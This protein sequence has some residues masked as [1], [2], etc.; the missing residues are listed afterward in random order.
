[1][2]KIVQPPLL[3]LREIGDRLELVRSDGVN[4]TADLI[5]EKQATAL[6]RDLS[7]WLYRRI[8]E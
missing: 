2:E 5:N 7:Q 4:F 1:V 8:Q 3:Y 6:I